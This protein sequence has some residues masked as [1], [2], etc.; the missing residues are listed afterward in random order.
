MRACVFDVGDF[1]RTSQ[2]WFDFGV[3]TVLA[4]KPLKIADG[5]FIPSNGG[6][7]YSILVEWK[8]R[9]CKTFFEWLFNRPIP[10]TIN[11]EYEFELFRCDADGSLWP[12]DAQP[13]K[14]PR[15]PELG[16]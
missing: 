4:T 13:R 1:V 11:W 14:Y 15:E 5:D 6:G 12:A 2:L 3:G 16:G 9:D 10:T 7:L 8:E